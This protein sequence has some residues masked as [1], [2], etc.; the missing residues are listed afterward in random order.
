MANDILTSAVY[1]YNVAVKVLKLVGK[2]RVNNIHLNKKKVSL[3]SQD[4]SV[5][6]Y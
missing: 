6:G 3:E 2:A 5:F 4:C 1:K